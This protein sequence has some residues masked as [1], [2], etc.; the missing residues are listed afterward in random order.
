M[1]IKPGQVWRHTDSGGRVLKILILSGVRYLRLNDWR[2]KQAGG[3][4][5]YHAVA[6]HENFVLEQDNVDTNPDSPV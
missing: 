6:I 2:N 5:F 3:T 4:G 1:E